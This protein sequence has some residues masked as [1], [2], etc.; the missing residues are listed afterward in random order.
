MVTPPEA[1][2]RFGS[3]I[4]LR[5]KELELSQEQLAAKAGLHRTYVGDIERG[6]RN[7]SLDNIAKLILAL[8]TTFPEF[9][10]TVF[11]AEPAPQEEH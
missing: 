10:T 7:V 1:R 2:Q 5:R 9:F 6:S 4:R 8:E 3:A 11:A